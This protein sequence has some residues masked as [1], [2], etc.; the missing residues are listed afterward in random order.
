MPA[1]DDRNYD[2]DDENLPDVDFAAVRPYPAT[3]RIAGIVWIVFGGLI[4]LSGIVTLV[5]LAAAGAAVQGA[6]PGAVQGGIF[7][8]GACIFVIAALFGA[9]FLFVGVQTVQGAATDTLGNS[10]GSLVFGALN[11][12]A[13]VLQAGQAQAI[14][15]AINFLAGVGLI[16]AGILAL[17]GREEYRAWR[18]AARARR[19]RD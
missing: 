2:E 12:G 18:R 1:Y 6:V 8:G 16:A 11:L 19:R 13:G 10:I 9:A 7:A 15:A 3:V 4:L 14:Q 17:V 5:M